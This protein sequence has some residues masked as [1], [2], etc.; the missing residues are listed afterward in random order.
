MSSFNVFKSILLVLCAALL[1]Q[2]ASAYDFMVD[3]LCYNYNEDGTS[4]TVTSENTS[5]PWYSNLSGDITI[6]ENVTYNGTTYS[7]TVIGNNSFWGC[8]GL[9]SVTIPNSVTTIGWYAFAGCSGLTSMTIPNSVTTIGGHAFWGCTSLTEVTIPNSVTTIGEGTFSSCR[10]LTSMTIP[11]SV[12]S[13]GPWVFSGC[14]GLTSVTIPNSVTTIGWYAFEG[15]TGLTSATIP[16]SVTTIYE[17]IFSSCT[18]LTSMVVESGNPKYDS[19]NN[20]NAI[21]E[22]ASNTLIGGCKNT[23]IP[24]SVTTIDGYAFEG[25]TG[26][27]S[28]TIPNTVTYIGNHAFKG[29]S[30]LTS[31]VVESGNP[32]YDSRNNCNAII[33]TASNTLI[34]G[35]KNTIIPNSVTLID[36]N[37]FYGCT[38]LTSV[39][40]PNTVT[41]IG[42]GAFEGCSGLTSVTI[43]NSVTTIGNGAFSECNILST[44]TSKIE[45]PESVTYYGYV[46]F[47]GVSTNYCKLYVPVGTV[48]SYKFTYPW[49][50]FSNII[51]MATDGD[52]NDDGIVS[53]VD[54]T[55]LYN[56]LLDG[57]SEFLVNGDQDGDGNITAADIMIIYN[58]MLGN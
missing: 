34:Y 30:G 27:T 25:C 43:G 33:E 5:Y 1:P 58:I 8:T 32:K 41:Y 24:N 18:S 26:L 48:E 14:S 57:D 36:D 28:V 12:T 6:P 49:R 31:M 19:R 29:C 45:N 47:K 40:I 46:I 37:A 51:E 52:V 21:I 55:V 20:C 38:G 42:N 3:G 56:F 35:C 7:V 39:T 9:T 13:I 53:S 4:V 23:I 16:N 22:T 44:I 2:L 15:C 17:G 10:G 50:N 11:N 54:V